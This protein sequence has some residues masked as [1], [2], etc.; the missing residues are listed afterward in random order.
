M[1]ITPV[2][3]SK[4]TGENYNLVLQMCKTGKLKCQ[5]TTGGHFKIYAS[6]LDKANDFK[7]DF[8][9]KKEYEEVVRENERLK[10]FINQLKLVINNIS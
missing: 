5:K 3:F 4:Q 9:S 1:F 10:A 8:I 6:E 7:E 2:E